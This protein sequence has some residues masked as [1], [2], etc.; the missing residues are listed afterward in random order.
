[1]PGLFSLPKVDSMLLADQ[2][3]AHFSHRT[4]HRTRPRSGL[5]KPVS[6]QLPSPDPR[7]L[8]FLTRDF[9]PAEWGETSRWSLWEDARTDSFVQRNGSVA[10]GYNS[11]QRPWYK[12][13]MAAFRDQTL[14]EAQAAAASLVAWTDVYPLYTAEGPRHLPRPWPRAT[15]RAKF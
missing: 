14:P 15:R 7:H 5:L 4:L 9:R 6:D 8:Q 12:V 3:G 2:K 13:A 11:R 10:V 1:M